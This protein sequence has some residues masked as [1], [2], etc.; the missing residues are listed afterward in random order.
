MKNIL[1]FVLSLFIMA[2]GGGSSTVPDGSVTTPNPSPTPKPN[3]QPNPN[4]S[5]TDT[6]HIPLSTAQNVPRKEL[7]GATA[8]T[9]T[10][11]VDSNL[12]LVRS[13][14]N[15]DSVKEH[16]GVSVHVGEAG[17][18]GPLLLSFAK[19]GNIYAIDETSLTEDQLK[20]F[21]D[22]KLYV[23]VKTTDNKPLRGQV[24]PDNYQ[25]FLFDL[26]GSQQSPVV[27]TKEKAYGYATLNT[28]SK[29]LDVTV[30]TG[31]FRD[32]TSADIAIGK[33]GFNGTTLFNLSQ[34]PNNPEIWTADKI[35]SMQDPDMAK[36][37]AGEMYVNLK[38]AA[39]PTGELRGQI[40][41]KNHKLLTFPLAAK[42]LVPAVT[43]SASGNGYAL[44]NTATSKLQITVLTEN[45]ADQN[46]VKVNMGRAGDNGQEI[47]SL[48]QNST[49][50]NLWSTDTTLDE[51]NTTKLLNG[52]LYALVTSTSQASGAA[53]GQIL[54]SYYFVLAFAVKGSQEVPPVQTIASGQGYGTFNRK[55]NKLELKVRTSQL[56]GATSATINLAPM[57]QVGSNILSL[58][59]E[60]GA[61]GTWQLAQDT[62]LTGDQSDAMMEGKLYVNIQTAAHPSGEIRG[63]LL[64]DD[65]EVV[66]FALNGGQHVP[67][68][69][70]TDSANGYL[71]IDKKKG[72][73]YLAVNTSG[74]DGVNS[75][76]LRN[77]ALGQN[78]AQLFALVQDPN[79]S[80][81]WWLPE[82]SSFSD[83]DFQA[84]LN[85][86]LYVSVSTTA[87]PN[88][89]I[90]GQLGNID[91]VR[92]VTFPLE[93]RQQIPFVF[94]TKTAAGYLSYDRSNSNI[95]IQITSPSTDLTTASLNVGR[96]G[97]TGNKI[98]DLTKQPSLLTVSSWN[99]DT[100]LA[101]SFEDDL[102][103]TGLYINVASNDYPSGEIR[104][105]ILFG[106]Y[107][108]K[109][110]ALSAQQEVPAASSDATGDGYSLYNEDDST[111]ELRVV[112]QD[113]DDGTSA[114]L[115]TG[116]P[117][118]I[119]T[120]FVNLEDVNNDGKIW[121]APANTELT[122]S[123]LTALRNADYYVNVLSTS[124]PNGE[125]RGQI[126]P[127]NMSLF[128]FN[129]SGKQQVPTVATD[130]TGSGYI[131]VN[132]DN[133]LFEGRV[134][135]SDATNVGQVLVQ[136]GEVGESGSFLFGLSQDASD[137]RLWESSGSTTVNQNILDNMKTGGYSINVKTP[138]PSSQDLIRGQILMEHQEFKTMEING[139]QNVPSQVTAATGEGYAII[140][141]HTGNFSLVANTQGLANPSTTIAS[142]NDGSAGRE[143][144]KILDLTEN[145]GIFKANN[146]TLNRVNR[147]KVLLGESYVQL[148]AQTTP[149]VELR[150]QV[151]AEHEII[152]SYE[153]TP[154]QVVP[155]IS[156]SA[157]GTGY[158]VIDTFDYSISGVLR[159]AN[160]PDVA[161]ATAAVFAGTIGTNGVSS[162]ELEKDPND[163]NLWV[164]KTNQPPLTP[165]QVD[166]LNNGAGYTL[167]STS[168]NPSGEIRGQ[169]ITDK[170]QV[171]TFPLSGSQ[172]EPSVTTTGSGDGYCLVNNED[173]TIELRV[174]TDNI[175]NINA[176]QMRAARAGFNDTSATPFKSLTQVDPADNSEWA[177][178]T[179]DKSWDPSTGLSGGYYIIVN[180]T[181]NPTGEIRGQ[182]IP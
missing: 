131:L 110:F 76:R 53:R 151:L 135:L 52:D 74:I 132:N 99:L 30:H 11:E 56:S 166:N 125:I 156:S 58:A 38:S 17:H 146:V 169:I 148:D 80:N 154:T 45:I 54:S 40:L 29:V 107:T 2:C 62:I 97:L 120:T 15:A 63:Q 124:H 86:E 22:G 87:F 159:T 41:P 141:M 170:Y 105:Q 180:S 71:L 70:T 171:I 68:V 51:S 95:K 128:P 27:S 13:S 98:L 36:L 164:P 96:V 168:S 117:G 143:G 181:A 123:Q 112:T 23:E 142:L 134:R 79:N 21:E 5:P 136:E 94:S 7:D 3:P 162:F 61:T 160:V 24:L 163:T 122:A 10:I 35:L 47:F 77:G 113:I 42:Q 16:A 139:K 150:G 133:F 167:V 8:T 66:S 121:Q 102:L 34:D 93:G 144:A 116:R 100:T 129:I 49:N 19:T 9:L 75:V 90:R 152:F 140:D 103:M 149:N 177:L 25:L 147:N 145:S 165:L 138:T 83:A 43:S 109:Y 111:L 33:V 84:F 57:G 26:T 91:N 173:S 179:A 67:M 78:G 82:N 20:L 1:P 59:E 14:F 88:G 28:D 182:I 4:F 32:T 137:N 46:A 176:V 39:H 50:P 89:E 48:Q 6:F 153:L 175:T 126:V 92:I 101:K 130:R 12:K 114:T 69:S 106:N 178:T 85:G 81:I 158:V 157:T 172:V 31:T 155:S 115:S 73:F 119:G 18:T 65:Y 55:T 44:I 127:D 108:F 174:L 118:K 161:N 64:T 72:S 104:G 60:T 37:Q